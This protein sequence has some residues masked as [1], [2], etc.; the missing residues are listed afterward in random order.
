MAVC[1]CVWTQSEWIQNKAVLW[2]LVTGVDVFAPRRN[3]TISIITAASFGTEIGN[4]G[5]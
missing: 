3:D 1:A 5:N 4:L 2:I